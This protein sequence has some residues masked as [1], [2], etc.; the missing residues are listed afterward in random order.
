MSFLD[1]LGFGKKKQEE[2]FLY[3]PVSGKVISVSEVSDEVFSSKTLGDGAAVIPAGNELYAPADGTVTMVFETKHALAMTTESG[4]EI[5]LHI[6]LDTVSLEGRYFDIQVTEGTKVKKGELIGTAD[7]E[8]IAA[9]GLGTD[10]IV[11]VTNTDDFSQ[12]E[13][14][15]TQKAEGGQEILRLV[16]KNQ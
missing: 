14:L 3:A 5:L 8:K 13:P 15:P 4:T 12:I 9:A 10:T 6:G 1:K 2:E 7:F 11:V 16:R